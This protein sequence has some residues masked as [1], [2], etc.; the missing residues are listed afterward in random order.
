[1]NY[2]LL[3][4]AIIM[5]VVG[6]SFMKQA[7]G[8]TKLIPSLITITTYMIAFYLLSL[9]MRTIPTG[10]AYAIWS[11]AG[12]FLIAVVA[13]AIQGQRL[14]IPA[15]LGMALIVAGVVVMNVFSKTAAH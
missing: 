10:I 5:E 9:T 4:V 15:M 14:D 8:F 7:E 2:I 11:G 13:W 3:G 12:I 1:M 6:T